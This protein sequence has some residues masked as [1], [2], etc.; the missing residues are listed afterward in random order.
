MIYPAYVILETTN[1]CNLKCVDCHFHGTGV[2]QGRTRGLM[3]REVWEKAIL[4]A[5]TW[6]THVTIAAHGA[7][8]PLL[9]P[10]L[11]KILRTAAKAPN[12]SVGFMTNGVL[13]DA[14]WAKTLVDLPVA[15]ISFSIDGVVPETHDALRKEASLLQIEKNVWRLIREKEQKGIQQPR[16]VFNMVG[17]P[18]ILGQSEAFVE[19][20]LPH[21]SAVTIAT[22]RPVGSRRLGSQHSRPVIPAQFLPCNLL[23]EQLVIGF[24][25]RAGL[26]CEDIHLDVPIGDV[27]TDSLMSLYNNSPILEKYRNIHSAEAVEPGK[28]AGLKL[29]KDCDVWASNTVVEQSTVCIGGLNALRKV[30]PAYTSYSV[31]T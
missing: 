17:Y 20:W 15:W 18:S 28:I 5:S 4:E 24:D 21:A 13:L 27:K 9:H 11:E 7:G 10:E 23:T 22:H 25:G 6:P 3:A 26:C 14:E 31:A 16:L 12:I 2:S 19:K 29:C 30:T 8:E 1:H